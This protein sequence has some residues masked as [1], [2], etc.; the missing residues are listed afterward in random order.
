MRP[1]VLRSIAGAAALGAAGLGVRRHLADRHAAATE[2][3]LRAVRH[4][5]PAFTEAH[6]EGLPEPARRYL[7]HAIAP[8]TVLSPACRLWMTG[9]MRPA[10]GAP[11]TR[12]SAVETLAPRQGFVWTARAR[13]RGLPVRVR[14]HYAWGEGGLEV[15]ALGLLPVPLGAGPDLTRSARG[16]LVAEAVWC[17]TALVHPSVRWEAVDADRA[18]YTVGVDGEAISV[19]VAVDADGALREATLL[20]WGDAD[21]G[22]YRRVPYGMG[23]EAEQAFGGVTIPT[24]VRGGWHYGTDR[25]DPARAARFTVHRAVF[26]P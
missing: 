15:V 13:M 7:R 19:T 21:G 3:A 8:G 23:V 2:A 17:P 25:Y 11:A 16:R 26:A 18:Q 22:P 12:L 4:P 14:D 20:R 9:T 6:L 1:A 10:P 5:S 24:R